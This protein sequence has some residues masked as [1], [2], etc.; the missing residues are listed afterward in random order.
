MR[1]AAWFPPARRCS[2]WRRRNSTDYLKWFS[3]QGAVESTWAP[4]ELFMGPELPYAWRAGAVGGR[5]I[6]QVTLFDEAG[7]IVSHFAEVSG[8]G[9]SLFGHTEVQIVSKLWREL[10]PGM[11]LLL[12][13]GAPVCHYGICHGSLSALARITGADILYYAPASGSLSL[14]TYMGFQGFIPK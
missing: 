1:R 4:W 9:Y 13:G 2:R 10:R 3:S 14:R 5:H 11:T 12:Q 6:L 7:N 8:A